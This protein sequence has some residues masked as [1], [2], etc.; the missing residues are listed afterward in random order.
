MEPLE[1]GRDGH[2]RRQLRRRRPHRHLRLRRLA[3]R[4]RLQP[5]LPRQGGRRLRRPALH[6]G[7][8][9]PRHLRPRLPRRPADRGRTSTT[10]ARRP[11]ATA[12]RPTRTRGACPGCGS[13]PP[14]P[15]AS[16]RS[17]RSTRRASTAICTNRGIKDTSA[18]PRLGVPRRRRDGRARVDRRPRPRRPRGAGQ[19]DLRH[20]LQPA[21]PRRPGPRQLQDRAGAGGPVPRRRL[22][23]R[24]VAVGHRLGR[25]VPARHHGRAG[26]PPARGPGR[27]VPD[28]RRP[29][30]PPTSASTSSA[31]TR[32]SSSW[33]SC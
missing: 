9:L 2:P 12:C 31:P 19:P 27:A 28:V 23:R 24:Q 22:E 32:R 14:S 21:A 20:Q 10:S 7:P 18:L 1:R 26:P 11:A 5:L 30:T 16:A 17:P 4:D 3:L 8:R 6:P 33:R 29:A 13:S 25:A 15:W